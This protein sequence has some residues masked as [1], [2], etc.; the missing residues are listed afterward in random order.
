[1]S[2]MPGSQ[3]TFQQ[4]EASGSRRPSR[5]TPPPAAPLSGDAWGRN[6]AEELLWRVGQS[7]QTD[8]RVLDAV[9]TSSV[10]SASGLM[11]PAMPAKLDPLPPPRFSSADPKDSQS[12][13]AKPSQQL[14]LR[15]RQLVRKEL[16]LLYRKAISSIGG[17]AVR[18]ADLYY[19]MLPP[20]DP[21]PEPRGSFDPPQ[22][23][24]ERKR[25]KKS[26]KSI[27][28]ATPAPPFRPQFERERR[29]RRQGRSS[30][31]LATSASTPSLSTRSQSVVPEFGSSSSRTQDRVGNSWTPNQRETWDVLM[32][33]GRGCH[34]APYTLGQVA[35]EIEAKVQNTK[36]RDPRAQAG[37]LGPLQLGA[38]A[39]RA[40]RR[41]PLPVP[42]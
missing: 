26:D 30:G 25:H 33:F 37:T 36:A 32:G 13:S 7:V 17:P 24:F 10:H 28:L 41:L 23:M 29:S 12:V 40:R 19:R 5:A 20:P 35:D 21:G 2:S 39:S 11:L 3:P 14:E 9:L 34:G 38:G 4:E 27:Y 18:A 16:R 31:S 15:V 42:T 8:R 1:M 6:R 22:P